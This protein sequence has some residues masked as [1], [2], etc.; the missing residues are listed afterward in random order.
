[1]LASDALY[2]LH[3]EAEE[4]VHDMIPLNFSQHPNKVHIYHNTELI[5]IY[6]QTAST[7][8]AKPM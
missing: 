8:A 2:K 5:Q 3:N 4:D 7:D 6:S 1:M